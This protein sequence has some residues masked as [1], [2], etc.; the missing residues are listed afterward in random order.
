[1]G[2]ESRKRAISYI[3]KRGGE[4]E[5]KWLSPLHFVFVRK[6]R[7][8]AILFPVGRKGRGLF[9]KGGT[10]PLPLAEKEEKTQV[11]RPLLSWV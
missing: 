11:R 9:G 7:G 3:E 2:K 4:G 10:R 1:M 8:V 5:G 6:E